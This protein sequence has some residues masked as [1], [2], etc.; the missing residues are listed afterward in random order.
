MFPGRT[1]IRGCSENATLQFPASKILRGVCSPF[2][3]TPQPTAHSF[4][5]HFTPIT[6]ANRLYMSKPAPKVWSL[7][8]PAGDPPTSSCLFSFPLILG[9]PSGQCFPTRDPQLFS[10]T[11]SRGESGEGGGFCPGVLINFC[12]GTCL[13]IQDC[14]LFVR[15]DTAEQAYLT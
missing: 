3:G 12:H 15:E 2:P 11:E 13:C 1:G 9:T 5:L 14:N 7:S 10:L 6:S 8:D 4:L